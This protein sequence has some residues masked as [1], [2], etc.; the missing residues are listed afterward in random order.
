LLT[1]MCS[2]T[3]A[4]AA[5]PTFVEKL[6]NEDR[7]SPDDF[8]V[9]GGK[10][11]LLVGESYEPMNKNA[12]D[13]AI[14]NAWQLIRDLGESSTITSQALG[15]PLGANAPYSMYALVS[16]S[17]RLPLITV[18]ERTSWVIGKAMEIALELHKD[19]GGVNKLKS[20]QKVIELSSA[21]IPDGLI[22]EANLKISLPQ[23]TKSNLQMAIAGI[24]NEFFSKDTARKD[25]YDIEQSDDETERIWAEKFAEVEFMKKYQVK[26][27]D[28]QVEVQ[29]K[30]AALQQEIQQSDPRYQQQIAMQQQQQEQQVVSQQA[31]IAQQ[32]Q[33]LDNQ[34]AAAM[35]Q[36][37]AG[38]LPPMEGLGG[39]PGLGAEGAQ[40]GLPQT[41]PNQPRGQP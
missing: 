10:K 39:M 11:K 28:A 19:A 4:L 41:E 33:A 5:N 29:R 22:V 3:F 37:G 24:N 6:L 13:P 15:E 31:Q 38:G 16:Q 1:I 34:R 14:V 8:S 26:L 20:K 40:E 2:N 17:G 7:T 32:Q 25:F 9:P 30:L 21:D 18:K 27:A 23:D 12:I 35:Q 36:Q